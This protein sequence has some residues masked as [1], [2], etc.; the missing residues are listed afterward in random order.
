M[1]T[2]ANLVVEI[3]AKSQKLQREL[4]SSL[5]RIQ[6]FA[7]QAITAIVKI[8][9]G[10]TVGL[11]GAFALVTRSINNTANEIDELAKFA[12]RI[13]IGV[14]ELQKL[15]F[16]AELTGVSAQT[17]NLALQRMTR[18]VAE[19]A[20]GTGEAKDALRELGLDAERLVQLRPDQQFNLIAQ[21]FKNVRNQADRVRL[22]MRLFD[23][24][25]VALVN[26]LTS[27][28]EETSKEFDELG[29]SISGSQA[30]VVEA[31][32][33]SVAKLRALFN[34][35]FQ[36]LTVQSVPAFKI[37]I[38][39]IV[40]VVKETGGIGRAANLVAQ[41][42]VRASITMIN[43][44]QGVIDIITR[45]QIVAA[46]T[47]SRFSLSAENR[48]RNLQ[49]VT[50]LN[51]QRGGGVVTQ[52]LQKTLDALEKNFE[53]IEIQGRK[54]SFRD[55]RSF[56]GVGTFT[57]VATGQRFNVDAQGRLQKVDVQIIAD[58]EGLVNAVVTDDRF[59]SAVD[60]QVNRVTDNAARATRR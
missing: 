22:A 7:K 55:E 57:D 58:R 8:G 51:N 45:F 11:A 39:Q 20:K 2:I 4:K 25:G 33:D 27:D 1:A 42:V 41:A 3:S 60:G 52:T 12:Q 43:A 50:R 32:V 6:K 48:V 14:G 34:G 35:F 38:D 30:A 40:A 13:G 15:Q 5:G 21:S 24:E 31:Y 17:L 44:L 19:A 46:F 16:Q 36:Q 29:I 56:K 49:E 37:L 54:D 9:A 18:R 28:L 53:K 23:T 10:I 26:T 59:T 47:R